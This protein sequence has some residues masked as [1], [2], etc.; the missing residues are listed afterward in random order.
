MRRSSTQLAH[1][2]DGACVFL[3]EKGLCRI[4]AKFGEPAKP[5]ACRI[6]PYAFHPA[7]NE[8]TVSLRFS[9]PSVAANR[10]RSLVQQKQELRQLSQLVVPADFRGT[11]PP[12]VSNRIKMDWPDTLRVVESLDFTMA[13]EQTEVATKLIRC[14]YWLDLVAAARFT[15]IRG[16]RL[17]E[18][19]ALLVDA[20]VMEIPERPA[21]SLAPSAMGQTQFRLLAGQY[22]RK[23]TAATID[24]TFAGRWKQFQNAI[25]LANSRGTLP[26]LSEELKEIPLSALEEVQCSLTPASEEML[27]RFYR[28]KLQGLHFCGLAYYNMRVIEGFQA[29]T[30]VYP[31]TLWLARWRA[32]SAGRK[33]VLH[34]DIL[35]ALTLVDHQHGYSPALGHWPAR[36]RVRNFAANKDLEKLIT[37]QLHPPMREQLKAKS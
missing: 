19:L 26:A 7:G 20:S 9:C 17:E 18:L 29:L 16:D 4:H 21:Q 8:L 34:E 14:L 3:N 15:K 6:Y 35:T 5:L 23:D 27:T 36:R 32:A 30:L 24:T 28:V 22:A 37:W 1:Q 33:N 11:P 12:R 31:A 25:Q 10:G 13:A 2:P